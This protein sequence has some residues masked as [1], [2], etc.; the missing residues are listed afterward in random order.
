MSAQSG[1]SGAIWGSRLKSAKIPPHCKDE[2]F[3]SRYPSLARISAANSASELRQSLLERALDGQTAEEGEAF[4]RKRLGRGRKAA[5]DADAA[6]GADCYVRSFEDSGLQFNATARHILG[7]S[8][9]DAA[10]DDAEGQE[11]G[12]RLS[13]EAA[14][15]REE[16]NRP[17]ALFARYAKVRGGLAAM[18]CK[19]YCCFGA[20]F[21]LRLLFSTKTMF[22]F[23]KDL[24]CHTGPVEFSPSTKDG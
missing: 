17:H 6:D 20:Q 5:G 10:A 8:S 23:S 3:R 24:F 21:A 2:L 9:L 19:T 18:G 13:Q 22:S 15:A 1:Q 11:H 16:R 4:E 12:A 14:I 7:G